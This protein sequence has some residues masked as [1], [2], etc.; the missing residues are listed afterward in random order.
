MPG[1]PVAL[2]REQEH[3][4][5]CIAACVGMVKA[6]TGPDPAPT[7]AALLAGWSEPKTAVGHLAAGGALRWWDPTDLRTVDRLRATLHDRWLVVTLFPGPLTFFTQQRR[8]APVSKHGPLLPYEKPRYAVGMPHA[9]VLVEAPEPAGV[10]YLD[11]YY[12]VDDQPFSLTEDELMEAWT[13][14]VV[15]PT[16]PVEIVE[17]IMES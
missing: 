8:P 9:V 11:P 5:S 15:I 2:H 14:Y 17:A 1:D 16:L 13:G 6:W 3:P 10:R 4:W 12:P 7:E